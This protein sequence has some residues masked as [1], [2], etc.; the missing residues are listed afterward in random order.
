MTAK[1]GAIVGATLGAVGTVTAQSQLR[2]I[3]PAIG[4]ALTGQ[5]EVY[6]NFRDGQ[7][8]Y[9][10]IADERLKTLLSD[11]SAKFAD[12]TARL[13]HSALAF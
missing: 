10:E 4:V 12:W 5:P 11:W 9:G 8:I 13:R 6:L 3:L 2:S 7:L 1:P